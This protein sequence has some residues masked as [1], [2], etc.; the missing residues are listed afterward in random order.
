MLTLCS[1]LSGVS[2]VSHGAEQLVLRIVMQ[3]PTARQTEDCAGVLAGGG[4][5]AP[6]CRRVQVQ[7]AV[8]CADDRMHGVLLHLIP[9]PYLPHT[10]AAFCYSL[11]L[12]S[13][14]L[15]F[16]VYTTL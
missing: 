1:R 14:L 8:H 3:V 10:A 12:S 16:I 6:L 7:C 15:L 4:G 13:S 2:V 5:G 9:A 11:S